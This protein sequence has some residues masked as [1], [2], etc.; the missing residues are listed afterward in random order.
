MDERPSPE[1]LATWQRVQRYVRRTVHDLD[2]D[3]RLA[4]GLGLDDYDLLRQLSSAP[5]GRRCM[6]DLAESTLI[7]RS[8]CTRVVD[9]LLAA[10]LVRRAADVG[11][12]RVVQVALTPAGRARLREADL[13]YESCVARRF[14]AGLDDDGLE[15]LGRLLDRWNA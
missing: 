7:T 11:D 9:R 4:H 1:A 3:L 14:S 2:G 15:T 13:T 12:R 10:G 6:R 8:S 5:T